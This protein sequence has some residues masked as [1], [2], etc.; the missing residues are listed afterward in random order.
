MWE[1][2]ERMK[3]VFNTTRTYS[4]GNV[5]LRELCM[6]LKKRGCDARIISDYTFDDLAHSTNRAVLAWKSLLGT[7]RDFAK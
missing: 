6:R 2:H 3:F 1:R 7:G 5:V 4:G